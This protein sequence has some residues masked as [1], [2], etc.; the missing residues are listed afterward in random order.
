MLIKHKHTF[1]L[2]K[3]VFINF[4]DEFN[5]YKQRMHG[6]YNLKEK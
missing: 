4:N 6:T 3:Y 2:S 5:F 1:I